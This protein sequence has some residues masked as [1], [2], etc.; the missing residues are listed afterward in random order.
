MG[1]A[2][3]RQKDQAVIGV[4]Y[5]CLTFCAFRG[6]LDRGFDLGYTGFASCLSKLPHLRF[7]RPRPELREPLFQKIRTLLLL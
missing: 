6:R 5:E 4:D 2:L 1:S 7:G 3:L